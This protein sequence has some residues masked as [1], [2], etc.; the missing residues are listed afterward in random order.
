MLP[1]SFYQI[2]EADTAHYLLEIQDKQTQARAW[3]TFG[4]DPRS[5]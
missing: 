5:G 2:N 1:S 4:T 3:E